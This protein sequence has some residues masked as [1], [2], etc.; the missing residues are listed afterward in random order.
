[1]AFLL[2]VIEAD[3]YQIRYWHIRNISWDK[4][5]DKTS[6]NLAG[7]FTLAD[8]EAKFPTARDAKVYTLDGA[9]T[10]DSAYV[11]LAL[12]SDWVGAENV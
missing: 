2:P 4:G 6:L 8:R 1:M 5:S 11:Q 7:Y 9:H 3:Q 12:L 10:V